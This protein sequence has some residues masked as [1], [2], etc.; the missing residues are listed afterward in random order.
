MRI[1]EHLGISHLTG[2]KRL[3]Q[4]IQSTSVR[5]HVL[6][7]QHSPSFDNFEVIEFEPND[8]KLTLMESIRINRDKPILNKTIQS[9]P[10]ELV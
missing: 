9:L 8:F 6:T 1:C 3:V 5:D 2:K 10:L 4:A 7:C